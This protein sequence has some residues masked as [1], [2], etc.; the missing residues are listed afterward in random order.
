MT[1]VLEHIPAVDAVCSDVKKKKEVYA[2]QITK[3]TDVGHKTDYETYWL[4]KLSGDLEKR[5][6]PYDYK[7]SPSTERIMKSVR[8]A[9]PD[10][11]SSELVKFCRGS[12][13][14]LYKILVS[15]LTV[16]LDKYS[17]EGLNDVILGAPVCRCDPE[18]SREPEFNP[19]NTVVAIRNFIDDNMSFNELLLEVRRTIIEA[20]ENQDFPIE[21]LLEKLGMTFSTDDF[22]L[23]DVAV[24]LGNIHDRHNL[25]NIPLSI[26]FSFNW[27]GDILE[28]E[29][30]YNASLYEEATI[31]RIYGHF[32]NLLKIVLTSPGMDLSELDILASHERE[33]LVYDFNDFEL[34][35]P[36]EKTINEVFEEQVN[37]TPEALALVDDNKRLNYREFNEKANQLARAL[38]NK[39]VRR[40]SIVGL[41]VE[42]SVEM[43]IGIMGILKAGGAYLPIGL[44]IPEARRDFMLEDSDAVVFL[45]QNHLISKEA[46][47]GNTALIDENIFSG[48]TTNLEIVNDSRDLAYVIYTSGT[49]GKPKGVMVEHWNVINL[50]YGLQERIYKDYGANLKV[51]LVAPYIFDASVQQIFGA[52]L[53]GHALHIVPE[54][55]RV[56]GAGLIEYYHKFGIEISDGTPSH[57]RLMLGAS[58][59]KPFDFNVKHFLIGGEALARQVVDSFLNKFVTP[60]PI[61]TNVYGPTECCVDSSSFKITID[62]LSQYKGDIITIG[63]PMPNEQ[64]YIVNK[65]SALQP[66]GV[67]GELCIG[68]D[69]VSRGYLKRP[70]LTAEKF[71]PHP[72][73]E[74]KILYKT[75]DIARWLPD[76]NIAFMDRIDHQ[77]KIRGFR[78][79][80]GEIESQLLKQSGVKETVVLARDDGE[81]EKYLCAYL[82]PD[83][84]GGIDVSALRKAL[85]GSL[86]S[87]MVPSYFVAIE[88]IPLTPNGKVNRNAL[89]DPLEM[90]I[91]K[92][93]DYEAPRNE[94][95]EKLAAI[96][97]EV[98]RMNKDIISIDGNFFKLGGHSLKAAVLITMIHKILDVKLKM[99][100]IFEMP[101]I[102]QLG[103][104]IKG[105][106]EIKYK[107]IEPA[108]PKKY[109]VQT[110]AQKRLFFFAQLEKDSTLYNM[111]LLDIYHRHTEKEKL[112]EVFRKLIK[113]H[114][115]LRSSFLAIEGEAVQKIHDYE[116]VAQAFELEYY[117]TDDD[118]MI[119]S[120]QPG[121]EWTKV[122]GLPFQDVVEHFV[123][124]FDLTR[125]PLIRAGLIDIAGAIQILMLDQHH[126]TGD[127]VSLVILIDELW[128]LYDG[129]E[130]PPVKVQYKDYAE[131]AEKDEQKAERKKLETFWLKEFEQE[132][133]PL[134]LPTDSP[135][136]PKISFDG[137]TVFF[138]IS[139]ELTDRLNKLAQEQGQTLFMALFAA[140]NVLM[141]KLSG[142]DDIIAG[143]VTAGRSHADVQEIIGMFVGT[144]ALRNY[145][146]GDKTFRRFLA[147]VKDRTIAAFEHQEY[148]LEELVSKVAPRADAGRN[149]LFDVVFELEN[150]DDRTEYL[151]ETLMLD[152]SNPYKYKN[153]TSK[154]DM[155]MVAVETEIG[156]QFKIE[157]S[158]KLFKESTI[159]RF[160]RYF[161]QIISAVCR[162]IDQKIAEIDMLPEKERVKVLYDFNDVKADYPKDK[163]IAELFEE[164]VTKTPENIAVVFYDFDTNVRKPISYRALNRKADQLAY[165]L[166]EKG[167]TSNSIVGM[168]AKKSVE[169]IIG[170]VATLKAG[171]AYLPLN[172]DYPIERKKYI[173]DDCN[174]QILL[175]NFEDHGNFASNVIDLDDSSIFE[176]KKMFKRDYRGDTLAYIMYTSG[177]TGKPKG[178]MVDQISV[179]RLVKNTNY[180]VFNEDESILQTGALEFDAST[181]ELWG[182]LL[183]GMALYLVSKD[184]ILNADKLKLSMQENSITTIWMTS[185]LFN[186]MLDTDPDIFSSLNYLLTGGDIVSASHVRR[187]KAHVP[188]ITVINCYGPTENTTF[189]TFHPVEKNYAENI[190]IG[191]P[192]ANSTVYIL[193]KFQRPVPIGVAGELY[194]GGD[195]V[196][197]GYLNNPEMTNE[198][199]FPDPFI[200]GSNVEKPLMYATGDV[201]RWL[202]DGNIEFMGRIDFQVK[203]RGFRIEPGEIDNRLMNID[204]IEDA[205]VIARKEPGSSHHYLCAYIVSPQKVD[206]G[207]LKELL[208]QDLPA[209]MIPSYFIQ[210]DALPL[211]N[212]GKVERR[213]LPEPQLES[214]EE[215]Y[216]PPETENEK[217][218]AEIWQEVLGLKRVGLN[219]DFF[220]IGGDSIKTILVSARL[221]KRGLTIH[222]NDF[223]SHPTLRELGRIVK[224]VEREPKPETVSVN[225]EDLSKEIEADYMRYQQRIQGEVW[226]DLTVKHQLDNVLLT[227]GTGY[228][229]A[230]L[231]Q[232]L[233]TLTGATL[234]LPIRGDSQADAEKRLKKRLSVYFGKDFVDANSSRLVVYKGDLRK[235][236]LGI[237]KERFE[238][239]TGIVDTVVHPA[240][241]VKHFGKYEEFYKDNVEAT[242]RLLDFALSGIKK[243]FHFISTMDTGRGDIE[244]KPFL[245]FTEYCHD[246]GQRI[247]EV[248]I[249]SKFEAE[250]R[251]RSYRDKGLNTSIYRAANMTFHSETGKF[252][253]N[254][255]DNFFY[256]MLRALI[257]VGFWSEEM[258]NLEF[259]L[260]YVNQAANAI[261]MLLLEKNLKNET[262]HICNPD[263]VSFR[264]M[265]GLL[266]KTN[267]ELPPLDPQKNKQ[268]L[269][270]HEGDPEYEKII[271]RVK[272]YAWEWE[273]MP[274]TITIPK[275]DRTVTLLKKLGFQW[276]EVNE[277]RIEK[278]IA[279]CKSVGFL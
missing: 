259:D 224:T 130:L 230:Y 271:E 81:G 188:G 264:D 246:E 251:V 30:I 70:Q 268:S 57:L 53:L 7:F 160:I 34:D 62:E 250:K 151:L 25:Q 275:M 220:Q 216:I 225:A 109:Y 126:I 9:A 42:R 161:E 23:F 111:P 121:K 195:G 218:L 192:I 227:G 182:C 150:E 184:T 265:A 88:K 206:I 38:R 6:F 13:L 149:P 222:V 86:P 175:T 155:L 98:L 191:G 45:T 152:T 187:L 131:W 234:H 253:E 113:R 43:M 247:E 212:N 172:P 54:D 83:A 119:F 33:R 228:L 145:P 142:Q 240:A 27:I 63:K 270:K 193:D 122:T 245:L 73:F 48:D 94:I 66:L 273:R 135:R 71:I 28:S 185:A 140:F 47:P 18:T 74:N 139:R 190:P 157:Y 210:M 226:P 197:R 133:S 203:I 20:Y 68:G 198:K 106:E 36:R 254:I 189:S 258:L 143:T 79:E 166:R 22:P 277:Q 202:P 274:G 129:V 52:L 167:V 64:M 243:E 60:A 1:G 3:R 72:L 207:Q 178:V 205:I 194:V 248:Y 171:G 69:G 159:E 137:D 180:M 278:M 21:E 200:S 208:L 50:V 11:I 132:I 219:D 221:Q 260:S 233:L 214:T 75:G 217:L 262:Y 77:V 123:R 235:E 31:K 78:I 138:E 82:I 59:E 118:G 196:S 85:D 237:P 279:H 162:N 164:Q 100:E 15:G 148:P 127:G 56:D 65:K 179:V 12:N 141:A 108:P 107:G 181:F 211:N 238:K 24:S 256:S 120:D 40:D 49:T 239:L 128:K 255:E 37:K 156:L 263:I 5:S 249:K 105:A 215:D 19:V 153:K 97:S 176:G 92:E 266:E 244:G 93:A 267:I 41:M 276:S 183:N 112:E 144:L 90:K 76:G 134:N 117:E 204:F 242:E 14:K 96:W 102:R 252:Q 199:F 104:Y 16:L 114:E 58:P 174:T 99:S 229:G 173:M 80:I 169:M 10:E 269:L 231:L 2:M 272:V 32:V 186:Q 147:E 154:F 165:L 136:P 39:G 209:Y 26:V 87:Y 223:F 115:S 213:S 103:E 170:I 201:S 232:Q 158:T 125:P 110:S 241:N 46:A 29:V 61:V 35:Y 67:P 95:E 55:T 177:S 124:P 8:F 84:K 51:A 17:Y 91:E 4:R 89:P 163:T 236:R 168:M 257:K 116:E 146:K 101:T 44:Q 261:V